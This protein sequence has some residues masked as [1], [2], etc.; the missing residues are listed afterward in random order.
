[1]SSP[2]SNHFIYHSI[3]LVSQR[4]LTTP[5]SGVTGV[6]IITEHGHIMLLTVKGKNHVAHRNL[7]HMLHVLTSITAP[8]QQ[9]LGLKLSK[10]HNTRFL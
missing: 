6:S 9:N 3:K 2:K 7:F 10:S 4:P 1:M 5:S 8:K